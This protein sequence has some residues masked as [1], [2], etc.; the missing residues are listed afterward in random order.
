MTLGNLGRFLDSIVY[1]ILGIYMFSL[2]K[3]NKEKM[4]KKAKF[5]II[6]G[7]AFIILAIIGLF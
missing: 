3:K 7:I 2:Y 4:G 1:I 6:G 5:I